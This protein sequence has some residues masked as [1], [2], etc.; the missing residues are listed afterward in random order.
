MVS[1][2]TVAYADGFLG[3]LLGTDAW[4]SASAADKERALAAATLAIDALEFVGGGF[5]GRR[6]DPAQE[7]AFPRAPGIDI[8]A[9]VQQACALEAAALLEDSIDPAA[10]R[11]TRDIRQGV[12]AVSV[13]GVS[14]SYATQTAG[15][16]G[17]RLLSDPALSLLRPW[18]I[19]K[20]V[21]PIR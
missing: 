10:K 3:T 4:S 7:R 15:G 16:V 2:A 19:A 8:P 14:E 9:A 12:T 17:G 18:R 1:Y 13:G 11:R 21:Y 20:G 5:L 6:T